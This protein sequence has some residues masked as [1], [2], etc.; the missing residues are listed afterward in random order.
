[1]NS[2]ARRKPEWPSITVIVACLIVAAGL[3]GAAGW[4]F[5]RDHSRLPLVSEK[6]TDGR[7]G[8]QLS[9]ICETSQSMPVDGFDA[10]PQNFT[11]T[12]MAGVD[13]DGQSGWY[14]GQIAISETRKGT[15]SLDGDRIVVSRP[16]MFQKFGA[17]ITRE[18]FSIDRRTGAFL[19]SVTLQSGRSFS[20]IRGYCGL[21]AKAPF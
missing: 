10:P 11:R 19:Q 6:M 4:Y 9:L 12:V 3:G 18:E 14:Q 16:A 2:D 15:L 20:L 13:L 21:F 1:M 8:S 7:S 17:M 5:S